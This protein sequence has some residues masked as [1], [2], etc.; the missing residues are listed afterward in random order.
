LTS[1]PPA[2]VVNA[3]GIL[4]SKL[5]GVEDRNVFPTRGQT[6]LVRNECSKMY[7]RSAGRTNDREPTYII[8]RAYGGGTILGGSRQPDDWYNRGQKCSFNVYRNGEVDSNLAQR[9][10]ARCIA[11]AP[12]LTGGKG[13]EALDIIRHNVGLR[14]SRHGG[15]RVEAEII[16]GIG[17]VV[18][19]YGIATL[20]KW[21][22]TGASGAGYQSSWGMAMRAVEIL[23]QA[24]VATT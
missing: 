13:P 1:P 18:H 21:L 9:I 5:G 24:L 14:P 7:F 16:P 8:P 6:I 11:L 4:A 10:A 22:I 23:E 3:T 15:P 12:E 17:L 2:A 20:W 19:N